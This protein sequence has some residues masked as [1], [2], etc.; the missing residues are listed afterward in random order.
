MDDIEDDTSFDLDAIGVLE[1][2]IDEMRKV[3]AELRRDSGFTQAE[4]RRYERWRRK[5]KKC[6]QED[7]RS[8]C[9]NQSGRRKGRATLLRRLQG[10]A[11]AGA[12]AGPAAAESAVQRES[13]ARRADAVA[14]LVERFVAWRGRATQSGLSERSRRSAAAVCGRQAA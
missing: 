14:A 2:T 8:Q 6:G 10:R 4:L 3:S 11:I 7:V 9:V 5:K 12:L 1:D 13:L